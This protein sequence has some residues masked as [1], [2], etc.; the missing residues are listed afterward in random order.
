MR[1]FER[2]N[3]GLNMLVGADQLDLELLN[4]FQ[5]T[6]LTNMWLCTIERT[7]LASTTRLKAG[8]FVIANPPRAGFKYGVFNAFS[9]FNGNKK[10]EALRHSHPS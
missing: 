10:R 5:L 8:V 2:G 4:G 3:S 9:T 6:D 1:Q 7:K